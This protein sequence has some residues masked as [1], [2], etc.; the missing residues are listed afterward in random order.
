MN[1]RIA[2]VL[3]AKNISPSQLADDLGVQRSGISH[4]VNGRNKPSLDFVQK[5]IRLYPDISMQWILFGEGPMM[6]PF[7]VQMNEPV[8]LKLTTNTISEEK[9]KPRMMELF[10]TDDEPI[11]V[12]AIPEQEKTMVNLSQ[13][14]VIHEDIN[15]EIPE[16]FESRKTITMENEDIHKIDPAPTPQRATKPE[17]RKSESPVHESENKKPE[18]SVKTVR[19]ITKIL[20]FYNDRTFVEYS[21]G[22]E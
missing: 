21:P 15:V 2:L 7:P 14:P 9:P 19:K 11:A 18:Q 22:E 3:K 12:Q 16:E 4:I 5:L 10:N 1:N 17:L 8:N 20:I 13:E 6:N